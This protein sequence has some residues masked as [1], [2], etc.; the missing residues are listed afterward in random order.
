ML[1]LEDEHELPSSNDEDE[2]SKENENHDD[3]FDLPDEIF[4]LPPDPFKADSFLRCA[5]EDYKASTEN[6]PS[7][8][9]NILR[10]DHKETIDVT[11]VQSYYTYQNN[12]IKKSPQTLDAPKYKI[13]NGIHVPI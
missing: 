5:S 2:E 3:D 9:D 4:Q 8:R 7:N 12:S 1:V 10:E 13:T 11:Q 6:I